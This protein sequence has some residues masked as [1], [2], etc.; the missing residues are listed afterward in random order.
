MI[1]NKC[2]ATR[3]RPARIKGYAMRCD[4]M[5]CDVMRCDVDVHFLWYTVY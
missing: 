1:I 4:A 3:V 5:Q 2:E